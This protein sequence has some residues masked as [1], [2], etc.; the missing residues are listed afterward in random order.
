MSRIR[1]GGTVTLAVAVS[2]LFAIAIAHAE[3]ITLDLSRRGPGS[4][5]TQTVEPGT[6]E[7]RIVNIVPGAAYEQKL[8][9]DVQLLPP[10]S[11]KFPPMATAT[12]QAEDSTT[13]CDAAW[14]VFR[15]KLLTSA[16]EEEVGALVAGARR[17]L[18]GAKCP[19]SSVKA[20]LAEIARLTTWEPVITKIDR[21]EDITFTLSR[22]LETDDGEPET[23]AWMV[24]LKTQPR[25]QFLTTFGAS[26]IPDRDDR[27]Y[28]A[29]TGTANEYVV[30]RQV[31]SNGRHFFLPSLYFTWLPGGRVNKDF[32]FGPT[33]GIGA[34]STFA[35]FVGLSALYN[36]NL[37]LA[38]G[39]S[40][41]KAKRLLG[42][43]PE[44]ST[45][46]TNL[47]DDQLYEDTIWPSWFV[48][49]S[50]RLSL[51]PFE[52]A[53]EPAPASKEAK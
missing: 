42:K 11:G 33:V 32:C 6:I 20:D 29:E 4:V 48:A 9:R 5:I 52:S 25:G 15:K 27:Y 34:G 45:V 44:G 41:S 22:K 2:S 39:L 21:G 14:D 51:N 47:S 8:V 12:S 49:L 13:T 38:A 31:D 50:L 23:L 46:T 37:Q 26:L 7:F 3:V 28:L 24:V 43:Y 30:T 40:A 10:L 36:S 35:A 1:A 16:T 19:A 53:K 18:E 17:T